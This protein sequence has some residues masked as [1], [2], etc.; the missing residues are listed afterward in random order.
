MM[1]PSKEVIEYS[2]GA[3]PAGSKVTSS[4]NGSAVHAVRARLALDV[5]EGP[6]PPSGEVVVEVE[7]GCEL[8]GWLEFDCPSLHAARTAIRSIPIP[9]T[10][11]LRDCR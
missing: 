5:P 9:R 11:P 8:L 7:V 4:S 3:L 10:E 6:V 2:D 1:V